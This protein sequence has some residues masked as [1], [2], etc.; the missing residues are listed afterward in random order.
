MIDCEATKMLY[1]L[2]AQ[3]INF[4]ARKITCGKKGQKQGQEKDFPVLSDSRS[5]YVEIC[6]E[7]RSLIL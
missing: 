6:N 4:A 1:R 5:K 3:T 7:T 2:C